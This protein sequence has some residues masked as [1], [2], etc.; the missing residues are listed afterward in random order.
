MI[1]IEVKSHE[2]R[3]AAIGTTEDIIKEMAAGVFAITTKL[4]DD[5]P[6]DRINNLQNAMNLALIISVNRAA[7]EHK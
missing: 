2:I 1:N 4:M 6:P 5:F 3:A 7:K